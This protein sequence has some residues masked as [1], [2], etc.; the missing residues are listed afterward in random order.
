MRHD[1][2]TLVELVIVIVVICLLAAILLPALARNVESKRRMA[3]FKNLKQTGLALGMYATD[4]AGRLPPMKMRN[5]KGETLVWSTIFE[6]S[7]LYPDYLTEWELLVCPNS[8]QGR[9]AVELWDKGRTPSPH[10]SA[11]SGTGDGIVNQCEVVE[12]PYVY[13]GWSISYAASDQVLSH[14]IP[15]TEAALQ[16]LRRAA[17]AHGKALVQNPDLVDEDW[18]LDE[19]IGKAT[20]FHRL[21]S[22][23]DQDIY[24]PSG[25]SRPQSY[26]AVMWDATSGGDRPRF[27]HPERGFKRGS[28]VL[29]LDGHVEFCEYQGPYGAFPANAAGVVF[30]NLWR[31]GESAAETR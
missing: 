16:R 12:Y 20:V 27:A 19:P 5:C 7:V 30:D 24:G 11:W 18:V 23:L 1:G 14:V 31:G 4:N 26:R 28:N 13:I 29:F 9:T 22:D 15:W 6:P 2:F 8:A 21:A 25:Y 17:E 3:C 10:W